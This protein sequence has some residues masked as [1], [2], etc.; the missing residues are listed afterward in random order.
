MADSPWASP[1]VLV[2]KKYG[3]SVLITRGVYRLLSSFHPGLC[4]IVGA[5]GGFDPK[6]GHDCLD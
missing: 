1:V 6:G 3:V 5:L 2:T 4:G